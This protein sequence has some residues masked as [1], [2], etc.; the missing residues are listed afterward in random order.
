P[1]ETAKVLSF[2]PSMSVAMTNSFSEENETTDGVLG[3]LQ[4]LR[5]PL[6]SMP[7]AEDAS[8]ET[9]FAAEIACV[10]NAPAIEDAS[11]EDVSSD[12]FEEPMMESVPDKIA[13]R[14]AQKDVIDFIAHARRV[15]QSAAETEHAKPNSSGSGRWLA[16]GSAAAMIILIC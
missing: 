4:P 1:S 6:P 11:D 10:E 16:W 12:E 14:E 8:E 3:E 15:A 9:A 7:E 13:D 5:Q 2:E